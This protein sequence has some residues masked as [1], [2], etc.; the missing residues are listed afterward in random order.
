M[1]RGLRCNGVQGFGL[2][3]PVPADQLREALT[4][5]LDRAKA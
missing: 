5:A 1:I 4:A 2:A 3:R